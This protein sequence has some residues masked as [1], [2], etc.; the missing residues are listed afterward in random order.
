MVTAMQLKVDCDDNDGNI[1]PGAVEMC[2]T[3][4]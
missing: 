1:K 4:A 2:D 3:L